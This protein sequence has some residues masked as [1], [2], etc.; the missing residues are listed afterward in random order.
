MFNFKLCFKLLQLMYMKS[1]RILKKKFWKLYNKETKLNDI[2]LER[3]Q[4][5]K[6]CGAAAAAAA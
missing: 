2:N 1:V 3:N 4:R 6:C 5:Q